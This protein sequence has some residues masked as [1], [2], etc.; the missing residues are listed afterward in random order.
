MEIYKEKKIKNM[1]T[2]FNIVCILIIYLSN[3]VRHN[4][5]EIVYED[6]YDNA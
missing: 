6:M 4:G 1:C 2:I 3:K 5:I